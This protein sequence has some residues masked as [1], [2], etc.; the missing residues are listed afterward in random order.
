M[1]GRFLLDTN[2]V[3]A[4]FAAEPAVLQ[5]VASA[6]RSDAPEDGYGSRMYD[7][8]AVLLHGFIK[9]AQKNPGPDLDLAL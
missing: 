4:I 9:K 3:I 2:I 8:H 5:R 6:E 7:G 1:N